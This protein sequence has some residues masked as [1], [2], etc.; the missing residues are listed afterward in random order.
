MFG[1]SLLVDWRGVRD[2]HEGVG[3]EVGVGG[4]LLRLPLRLVEADVERD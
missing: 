3:D 1:V 2:W 4:A